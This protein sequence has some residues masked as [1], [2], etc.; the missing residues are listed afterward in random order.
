MGTYNYIT[1]K[2]MILV[3]LVG[4]SLLVYPICGSAFQ[5]K[6]KYTEL[7]EWDTPHSIA[8]FLKGSNDYSTETLEL[9]HTY[10]MEYGNFYF[11]AIAKN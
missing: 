4:L 10:M 6:A 2:T 9:D 11:A 8:E 7:V 3:L 5:W 1:N